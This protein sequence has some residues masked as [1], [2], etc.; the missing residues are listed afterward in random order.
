MKKIEGGYVPVI[1]KG[2]PNAEPSKTLYKV[3]GR[4]NKY[5]MCG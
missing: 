4:W 5:I 1:P 2:P 3:S